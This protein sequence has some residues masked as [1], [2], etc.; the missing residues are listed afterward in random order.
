MSS[1]PRSRSGSINAIERRRAE[2][3]AR[4]QQEEAEEAARRAER[5]ARQSERRR[6]RVRCLFLASAL[7]CRVSFISCQL[8]ASNIFSS[9]QEIELAQEETEEEARRQARDRRRQERGY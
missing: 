1:E 4:R 7:V 8:C 3:E 6:Q 5:E 9:H 2:R